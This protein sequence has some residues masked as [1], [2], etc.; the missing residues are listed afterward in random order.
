MQ[1][2]SKRTGPDLARIG[3]WYS[4]VWHLEHLRDPRAVVPGIQHA[5][6]QLAGRFEY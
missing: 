2:G 5:Q 3:W 4:N 1:W 6:I